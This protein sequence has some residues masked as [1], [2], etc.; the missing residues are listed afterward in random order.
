MLSIVPKNKYFTWFH[1][2]LSC[3]VV[4]WENV[5]KECQPARQ[6]RWCKLAI[7]QKNFASAATDGILP[8]VPPAP[9]SRGGGK[10]KSC[11]LLSFLERRHFP[12]FLNPQT[13]PGNRDEQNSD[14]LSEILNS[15]CLFA[16][17]NG[18]TS[19]CYVRGKI[20]NTVYLLLINHQK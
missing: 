16:G 14:Q 3:C 19:G 7:H 9:F 15:F 5:K 13:N 10:H 1:K 12:L 6:S 18:T 11:L 17:V 8:F 20:I 2:S 4:C